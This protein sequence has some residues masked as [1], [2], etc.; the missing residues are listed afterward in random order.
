VGV[1][2]NRPAEL[3]IAELQEM[4]VRATGLYVR[5]AKAF[6]RQGEFFSPVVDAAKQVSEDMDRLV[7]HLIRKAE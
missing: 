7:E 6:R 2:V 5:L 3:T 1:I 4:A